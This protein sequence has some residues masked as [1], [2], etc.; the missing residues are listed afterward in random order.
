MI[1]SLKCVF[2]RRSI[3][4]QL[5]ALTTGRQIRQATK[6]LNTLCGRSHKYTRQ[7]S[8]VQTTAFLTQQPQAMTE[9]PIDSSTPTHYVKI[10]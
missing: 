4:I 10:N 9:Q 6:N 5:V 1:G 2:A 8:C 3:E 7:S